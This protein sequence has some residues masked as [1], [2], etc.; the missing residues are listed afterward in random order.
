MQFDWAFQAAIAHVDQRERCLAVG[1]EALKDFL[2]KLLA[3]FDELA[4]VILIDKQ[5]PREK[6]VGK[7]PR[8]FRNEA[9]MLCNAVEVRLDLGSKRAGLLS[10]LKM[11]VEY[12]AFLVRG[13]VVNVDHNLALPE[14]GKRALLEIIASTVIN[15]VSRRHD[16]S[17]P[18][19]EHRPDLRQ[20]MVPAMDQEIFVLR[21]AECIIQPEELRRLVWVPVL[22]D[23]RGVVEL[24]DRRIPLVE[25]SHRQQG[26]DRGF[27][28]RRLADEQHKAMFV[29]RVDSSP[30]GIG[31]DNAEAF[32]LT[33]LLVNPTGAKSRDVLHSD[34]LEMRFY[35]SGA[36][37]G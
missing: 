7:A 23:L 31:N 27:A 9:C 1:V 36:G 32:A 30:I 22:L 25:C 35:F 18:F 34:G 3:L 4:E 5:I 37:A 10:Q 17:R 14:E 12:L 29:D 16:D 28:S 6:W 20:N 19:A 21:H 26:R 8:C 15:V 13:Q 11:I 2:E 33:N 24:K